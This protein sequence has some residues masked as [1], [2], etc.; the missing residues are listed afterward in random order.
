MDNEKTGAELIAAERHRQEKPQPNGEGY[1]VL[2]DDLHK[3]GEFSDAAACYADLA[4][5]Q[6]RGA[7]VEELRES[8]LEGLDGLQWPWDDEDFKPTPDPIRNL[9]KAGALLAAEIDR[10][11]RAKTQVV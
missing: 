1:S 11:Q 8:Y 9:V 6:V 10:L 2:H 7:G 4:S 5:A 3:L